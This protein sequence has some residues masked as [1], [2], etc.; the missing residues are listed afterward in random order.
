MVPGRGSRIIHLYAN[1]CFSNVQSGLKT[2]YLLRQFHVPAPSNV[3]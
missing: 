1:K 2:V 3:V